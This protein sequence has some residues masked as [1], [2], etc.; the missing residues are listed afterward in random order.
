MI[1]GMKN[2]TGNNWDAR[3]REISTLAKQACGF[4]DTDEESDVLSL[5]SMG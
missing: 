5:A 3:R 1:T 2:K 4:D